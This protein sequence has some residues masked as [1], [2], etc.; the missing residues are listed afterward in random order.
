MVAHKPYL[1]DRLK[2]LVLGYHLWDEV[3]VIVDDWH[4]LRMIVVEIFR[5]LGFEQE[6]WIIKLF[7]FVSLDLKCYEC[8]SFLQIYNF[9]FK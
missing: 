9:F 3:T 7:H 5:C 1:S 8:L 2:L 4:F 6:I